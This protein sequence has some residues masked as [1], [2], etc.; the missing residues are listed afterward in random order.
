MLPLYVPFAQAFAAVI[1][2]ALTGS[3]YYVATAP[4][5]IFA[6]SDSFF[7]QP[8]LLSHPPYVKSYLWY[9]AAE[10][11]YVVAPVLQSCSGREDL[12]KLFA[13]L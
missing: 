7:K 9:F 12:K 6:S 3:L 10:P 4:E 11:T 2:A 5:G 8:Q 1:T 13:G